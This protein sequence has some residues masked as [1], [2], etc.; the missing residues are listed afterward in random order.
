MLWFGKFLDCFSWHEIPSY[1]GNLLCRLILSR[2]VF[3]CSFFL[4]S[5]WVSF[6]LSPCPEVQRLLVTS[7]VTSALRPRSGRKPVMLQTHGRRQHATGLDSWSGS[8]LPVPF[9]HLSRSPAPYNPQSPT[10]SG[11]PCSQLCFTSMNLLQVLFSPGALTVFF[12]PRAEP[13]APPA[14]F[15]T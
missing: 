5:V 3:I 11:Q 9:A 2:K 1:F 6:S 15:Q 8:W 12:L 7:T 13:P 14:H 4:G 10:A